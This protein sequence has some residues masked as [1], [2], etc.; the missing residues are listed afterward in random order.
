MKKNMLYSRKQ[1]NNNLINSCSWKKVFYARFNPSFTDFTDYNS[2]LDLQVYSGCGTTKGCVGE[3]EGCVNA[4]NCTLLTTYQGSSKSD[5][6]LEIY[7]ILTQEN[8]YIASAL[9]LD[10]K[11]GEDSVMA[12]ILDRETGNMKNEYLPFSL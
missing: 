2:H 8:N 3:T 9:S 12:C 11:M 6:I 7:G 10:D 1:E 5:Y 4:K